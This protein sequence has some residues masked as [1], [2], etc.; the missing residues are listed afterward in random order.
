M[1]WAMALVFGLPLGTA[2]AGSVGSGQ[3]AIYVGC[4]GLMGY[5][6]GWYLEQDD[7]EDSD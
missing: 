3:W 7:D 4:F 1:R 6:A 5:I 2:V